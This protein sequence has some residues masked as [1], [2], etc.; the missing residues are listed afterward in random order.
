MYAIR[1]YYEKKLR[2]NEANAWMSQKLVTLKCDLFDTIDFETLRMH[3]ENPFVPIYDELQKYE[4]NGILRVLNAKKL[5]SAD[6]VAPTRTEA[7]KAST[8]EEYKSTLILD[9]TALEHAL[10]KVSSGKIVAF[11]TETTGRNNFV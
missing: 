1:S 8:H 10:G 2:E 9:D 5:V 11:D 3:G 7:P 4:M 6:S